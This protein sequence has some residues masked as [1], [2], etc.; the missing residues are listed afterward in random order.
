M[1]TNP[2]AVSVLVPIYKV[3]QYI[4]RCLRSLF[5]QTL[6]DIEYIFVDDGSPDRSVEILWEVLKDYPERKEQVKLIHHETNQGVWAVRTTA[7]K[8]ATG[9]YIIHCDSDDWV[10]REMYGTMYKA[11]IAENADVVCCNFIEE[12]P[13]R[14]MYNDRPL[15]GFTWNKLVKHTLYTQNKILPFEGINQWED[16]GLIYRLLYFSHKTVLLKDTY[17]HYNKQNVTSMTIAYTHSMIRQQISCVTLLDAFYRTHGYNRQY[18]VLINEYMIRA[19]YLLLENAQL[20]N[21]KLWKETFPHLAVWHN[22]DLTIVERLLYTIIKYSP[23]WI[24]SRCVELYYYLRNV[25]SESGD[26][27]VS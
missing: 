15:L 7:I 2:P 24:G 22:N 6:E 18:R 13:N 11:A 10:E 12:Y 27:Y 9:Q 14:Q 16:V 1:N 17:Y 25:R 4:E 3:E 26:K 8:A 19:K 21:I 23:V 5:E 20:R